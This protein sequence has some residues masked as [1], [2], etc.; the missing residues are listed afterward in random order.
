MQRMT[1][2]PTERSPGLFEFAPI[3]GRSVVAAFDGGR[4]TSDA[5]ALLL[6][7]TDRVIGLTR[8][9]AACFTDARNVARARVSWGATDAAKRRNGTV[10][11]QDAGGLSVPT[12]ARNGEAAMPEPW[13][14][15]P[16]PKP[17]REGLG[18]LRRCCRDRGPGTSQARS[19]RLARK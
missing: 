8:R 16:V 12:Q 1:P 10:R 5:G 15:R 3:A 17:Q 13:G 6:G 18:R 4:I 11:R 2:V 7:S 9:L 19:K 14:I